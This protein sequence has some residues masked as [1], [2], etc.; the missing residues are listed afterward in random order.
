M[1]V[2]LPTAVIG[3]DNTLV[4]LGQSGEIMGWFYPS[5]DHAQNIYQCMP[6]VYFGQP[7]Q[8]N[9]HWTYGDEW[10]RHQYYLGDSN[11]LVTELTSHARSES[12]AYSGDMR[13]TFTDVLMD[14]GATRLRRIEVKNVGTAR[15]VAG[16]FCFGD[17]NMGGIRTGN[18]V[19][20]DRAEN[21]V[22]QWHR[23]VSVA[24]GGDALE[25]W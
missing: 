1:P 10:Q 8:G 18:G 5:K 6:C 19:R 7:H 17:W 15:L 23:D 2:Y 14:E 4:T 22:V 25:E 12:A 9:L 20:Y 13:L 3:N 24:L 16:V 21:A 11:V